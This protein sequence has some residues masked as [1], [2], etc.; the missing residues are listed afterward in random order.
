MGTCGVENVR[1]LQGLG[2]KDPEVARGRNYLIGCLQNVLNNHQST[3]LATVR[4][5]HYTHSVPTLH[6]QHSS[7]KFALVCTKH[8]IHIVSKL[9]M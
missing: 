5:K 9:H 7:I 1:L 6:I 2:G 8:G 3:A 4:R